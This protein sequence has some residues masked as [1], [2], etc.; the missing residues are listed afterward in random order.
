MT[1]LVM[2]VAM[3]RERVQRKARDA[4]RERMYELFDEAIRGDSFGLLTSISLHHLKGSRAP[5]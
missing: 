2:L 5:R 3:V 1:S 4:K